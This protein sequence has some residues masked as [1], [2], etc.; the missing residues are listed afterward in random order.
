MYG[1]DGMII[2]MMKRRIET[3]REITRKLLDKEELDEK[4]KEF[5]MKENVLD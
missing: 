1:N 3:F 4:E 5:L 2:G